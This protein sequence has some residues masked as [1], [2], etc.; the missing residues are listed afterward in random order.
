MKPLYESV[1][2]EKKDKKEKTTADKMFEELG[3]KKTITGFEIARYRKEFKLKG[4]R[5]IIFS[6]D[7]EICVCEENEKGLAVNR[8]YFNMQELQ[9]INQKCKE[10]GWLD[11][12]STRVLEYADN[13]IVP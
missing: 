12:K 2:K 4:A 3:Y 13:P 9:A 8:D 11:N 5:N 7:K 10:L 6:I 1:K